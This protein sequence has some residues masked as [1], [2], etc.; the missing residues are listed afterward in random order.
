MFYYYYFVL[1][2]T[3]IF[4][5]CSSSRYRCMYTTAPLLM[6]ACVINLSHANCLVFS[7]LF[8]ILSLSIAFYLPPSSPSLPSLSGPGQVMNV[9]VFPYSPLRNQQE[10]SALVV[11][12]SLSQIDS[13]GR[14]DHYFV[15]ITDAATGQLL[16]SDHV[17]YFL[18]PPSLPS[19]PSSSLHFS[20]H[21]SFLCMK[22]HC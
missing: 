13:G 10:F 12:D 16:T 11:W 14:V 15:N 9:R 6:N 17:S 2:C 4:I 7:L 1:S 19:S 21:F 18:S 22:Q 3:F 8:C 5:G 20:L